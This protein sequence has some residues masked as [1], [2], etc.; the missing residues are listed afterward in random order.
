[1]RNHRLW[2]LMLGSIALFA[3][4]GCSSNDPPLNHAAETTVTVVYIDGSQQ[5][6]NLS[7]LDTATQE[8]SDIKGVLATDRWSRETV[9]ITLDEARQQHPTTG[10][11]VVLQNIAPQKAEH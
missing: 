7:S 1:M 9:V 10:Q 6:M 3:E 4:F 2:M 5:A 11:Y 8:R